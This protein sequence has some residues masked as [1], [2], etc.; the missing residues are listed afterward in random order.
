MEAQTPS[1]QTASDHMTLAL[2]THRCGEDFERVK[3]LLKGKT[4]AQ[5]LQIAHNIS[6]KYEVCDAD[7]LCRRQFDALV[8][9]FVE[10]LRFILIDYP[11][12]LGASPGQDHGE[13]SS[14]PEQAQDPK[15]PQP[16]FSLCDTET[17]FPHFL[18][19]DLWMMQN[20]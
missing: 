12:V 4:K 16:D 11:G 18:Y 15:P 6:T 5:L 2:R 20:Q 9:W 10:N 13:K 17:E 19:P 7:R 14:S 8:C 1:R 3:D